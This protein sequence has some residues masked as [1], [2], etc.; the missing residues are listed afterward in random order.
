MVNSPI[1]ATRKLYEIYVKQGVINFKKQTEYG[2]L[3]MC[4]ADGRK[5]SAKECTLF[6]LVQRKRKLADLD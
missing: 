5:Q 4:R 1:C 2:V 3:G 6:G